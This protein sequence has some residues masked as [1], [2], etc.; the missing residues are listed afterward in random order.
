[1]GRIKKIQVFDWDAI[2]GIIAALAAIILHFLH[3]VEVDILLTL[4]T[5][6]VAV[7]FIR[8]LR[9]DGTIEEAVSL[10]KVN[11][12]ELRSL[13]EA[14]SSA[15][16]DLIDVRAA[17]HERI[18]TCAELEALLHYGVNRFPADKMKDVWLWLLWQTG[19]SYFAT[20]Y[21]SVDQLYPT[22][23]ADAALAAQTAKIRAQKVNIRKVFIVDEPGELDSIECT[24][25]RSNS[26][27][28]S[29]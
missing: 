15:R 26:S 6:L 3:L 21:M 10:L 14:L 19:T 9:R 2:A 28:E 20:N 27:K 23:Y 18:S 11:Q 12:D 25:V 13:R 8:Q 24:L 17:L 7:L 22:G 5:V 16:G 29:T 1:M 4:S